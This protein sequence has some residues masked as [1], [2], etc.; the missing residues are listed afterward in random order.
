MRQPDTCYFDGRC[1]LCRRSRRVLL[2]LDWL[3]ALR[4]E[5]MN[6]TPPDQLPVSFDDAMLGMPMRTRN[7]RIL[8]GYEAVRRALLQTPLGFG[9]ACV[10]YLPG[11]AWVGRRTYHWIARNRSRDACALTP[12]NPITALP[13]PTPH[14]QPRG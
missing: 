10:L 5:D 3:G 14:S 13:P 6:L 4:F 12:P 9:L 7:G 8:L 11:F 1:G 2:A